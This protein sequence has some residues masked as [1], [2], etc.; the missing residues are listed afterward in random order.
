MHL[1]TRCRP[2]REKNSEPSIQCDSIKNLA[3]IFHHI[4]S[5]NFTSNKSRGIG[6]EFLI[7]NLSVVSSLLTQTLQ[8][9]ALQYLFHPDSVDDKHCEGHQDNDGQDLYNRDFFIFLIWLWFGDWSRYGLNSLIWIDHD[10]SLESWDGY[11][12]E[13]IDEPVSSIS[14]DFRSSVGYCSN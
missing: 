4:L 14:F 3:Y 7:A 1:R 6:C 9:P 2:R 11:F 12:L 5:R 13:R 10:I 8:S